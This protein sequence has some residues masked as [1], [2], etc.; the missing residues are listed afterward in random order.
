ML[1]NLLQDFG[2]IFHDSITMVG[3]RKKGVIPIVTIS[4]EKDDGSLAENVTEFLGFI[5][6]TVTALE[7]YKEEVLGKTTF[8]PT[9]QH[10][11]DFQTIMAGID[12]GYKTRTSTEYTAVQNFTSWISRFRVRAKV[13]SV[14]Q[15]SMRMVSF[16][17]EVLRKKI[18][19]IFANQLASY[20]GASKAE[21]VES[22]VD[23][24]I[25][26]IF[27][28]ALSTKKFGTELGKIISDLV[29]FLDE[30]R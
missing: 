13:R 18:A 6:E 21:L 28:A 1:K 11:K 19:T 8:K 2:S 24:K 3:D 29:S 14:E 5:E 12:L 20:V 27:E 25:I 30:Q 15:V 23:V 7:W 9:A 26:D 22:N 16:V 10:D 4:A 17:D